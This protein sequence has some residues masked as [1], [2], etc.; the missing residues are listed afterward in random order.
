MIIP[1][2]HFPCP[3]EY[4]HVPHLLFTVYWKL[5]KLIAVVMGGSLRQYSMLLGP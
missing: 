4:E 5:L 3:V 1:I 2:F